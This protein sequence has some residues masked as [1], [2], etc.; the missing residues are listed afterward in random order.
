MKMLKQFKIHTNV[1]QDEK[2]TTLKPVVVLSRLSNVTPSS[3][4][5]GVED[6]RRKRPEKPSKIKIPV[7]KEKPCGKL[8]ANPAQTTD[9]KVEKLGKRVLRHSSDKANELK[10]I[11]SRDFSADSSKISS[12]ANRNCV[13]K[14]DSATLSQERPFKCAECGEC[15]HTHILLGV[16]KRIHNQE[17]SSEDDSEIDLERVNTCDVNTAVALRSNIL[18][19]PRKNVVGLFHTDEADHIPSADVDGVCFPRESKGN[20]K[21]Q[22]RWMRS[23]QPELVAE[24]DPKDI[25]IQKKNTVTRSKTKDLS[26]P[27]TPKTTEVPSDS[28]PLLGKGISTPCVTDHDYVYRRVQVD[29]TIKTTAKPRAK[30]RNL[31]PVML[32]RCKECPVAFSRQWYVDLHMILLHYVNDKNTPLCCPQCKQLCMRENQLR[33]HIWRDHFTDYNIMNN[34]ISSAL[35]MTT[36]AL[37]GE[38]VKTLKLKGPNE[39]NGLG[40]NSM[41]PSNIAQSISCDWNRATPSQRDIILDLIEAELKHIITERNKLGDHFCFADLQRLALQICETLLITHFFD[42]KPPKLWARRILAKTKQTPRPGKFRFVHNLNFSYLNAVHELS[43]RGLTESNIF[44]AFEARLCDVKYN[45]TVKRVTRTCLGARSPD[46]TLDDTICS[47]LCA[48]AIGSIILQPAIVFRG[49]IRD[50]KALSKVPRSRSH[51]PSRDLLENEYFTQWFSQFLLSISRVR[52][53][54]LLLEGHVS[55]LPYVIIKMARDNDIHIVFVPSRKRFVHSH[56]LIRESLLS[57][58]L[59]MFDAEELNFLK[60]HKRDALQLHDFH[61]VFGSAWNKAVAKAEIRQSFKQAGFLPLPTS[62]RPLEEAVRG[63]LHEVLAV[64]DRAPDSET[65]SNP[66]SP[67]PLPSP[68]LSLAPEEPC[69]PLAG[70]GEDLERGVPAG[71][72]REWPVHT[73]VEVKN[74]PPEEADAPDVAALPLLGT[75]KD[76]PAD[77][78]VDVFPGSQPCEEAHF[79][80]SQVLKEEDTLVKTEDPSDSQQCSRCGQGFAVASLLEN[81]VCPD[82]DDYSCPICDAQFKGEDELLRHKCDVRERAPQEC[83]LYPCPTCGMSFALEATLKFHLT[84]HGSSGQ[85]RAVPPPWTLPGYDYSSSGAPSPADN[86]PRP[87]SGRPVAKKR[88]HAVALG[89]EGREEPAAKVRKQVTFSLPERADSPA[90]T[91]SAASAASTA[92]AAS[93]SSSRTLTA[94]PSDMVWSGDELAGLDAGLVD[95]KEEFDVGLV[96]A[97]SPGAA[98]VPVG[99]PPS[100]RPVVARAPSEKPRPRKAEALRV[101]PIAVQCRVTLPRPPIPEHDYLG[102]IYVRPARSGTAVKVTRSSSDSKRTYVGASVKKGPTTPVQSA[103]SQGTVVSPVSKST[104]TSYPNQ[105]VITTSAS[106]PTSRLTST[107]KRPHTDPPSSRLA[108]TP[109]SDVMHAPTQVFANSG[110]VDLNLKRVK[111]GAASVASASSQVMVLGHFSKPSPTPISVPTSSPSRPIIT[112]S[113]SP[114]SRRPAFTPRLKPI[115]ISP[116]VLTSHS[117]PRPRLTP[118]PSSDTI[119]VPAVGPQPS[120]DCSLKLVKVLKGCHVI[121]LSGAQL[122]N[123]GLLGVNILMKK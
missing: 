17:S 46:V 22:V 54:I 16:H 13:G 81:H 30:S 103:S 89:A 115:P 61:Q 118:T 21:A 84:T 10:R 49:E 56:Q 37:T 58:L 109:S 33:N 107:A 23:R 26:E 97:S 4:N 74:E 102:Q 63:Y 66:D 32:V 70:C 116:R 12:K 31:K 60:K 50:I 86:L 82:D 1:T 45:G 106:P 69:D 34:E 36:D 100:P 38:H 119:H 19:V 88:L 101:G 65:S 53:A 29:S 83:D 40:R 24:R 105:P 72:V 28:S 121:E 59:D 96:E 73:D 87:Q 78:D 113:T 76:E 112:T 15:F 39:E 48:N 108:P 123:L 75:V 80:R 122:H 117:S 104:P 14:L 79:P 42:G 110:F 6:L 41:N 44:Y 3:V 11:E 67:A 43:A 25:C 95:V 98:R 35:G 27:L 62:V 91:A 7:S 18:S 71:G 57:P 90:S 111:G 77:V 47:V 64:R 92:S 2:L 20:M 114:P 5:V 52:P 99:S 94:S 8:I 51:I 85:R 55:Q 9:D 93:S 68:S 120:N